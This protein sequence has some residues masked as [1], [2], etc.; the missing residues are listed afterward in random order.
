ML[1][2]VQTLPIVACNDAQRL[3]TMSP[4]VR[5]WC[6]RRTTPKAALQWQHVLLSLSATQS[7]RGTT[8]IASS[9]CPVATAT[10]APSRSRCWPHTSVAFTFAIALTSAGVLAKSNPHF[11]PPL[12]V[13]TSSYLKESAQLVQRTYPNASAVYA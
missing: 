12:W 5:Q 10:H 6:R 13:V 7:D 9:G 1:H 4:H 8:A 3:Q 2:S 11:I